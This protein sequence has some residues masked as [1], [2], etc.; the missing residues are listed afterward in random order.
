[1]G[2]LIVPGL[3]AGVTHDGHEHRQVLVGEVAVCARG[4]CVILGTAVV[5]GN[6]LAGCMA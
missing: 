2:G 6:A 1:M 5:D 4:T 3:I